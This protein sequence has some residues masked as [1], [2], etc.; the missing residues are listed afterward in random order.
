VIT[1]FYL[2]LIVILFCYVSIGL[3][4]RQQQASLREGNCLANTDQHKRLQQSTK[5]RFLKATAAIVCAFVLSW[6]PYQVGFINNLNLNN[7]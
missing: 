6:L 2:P 3:S 4:L 5:L 7:Y 1:T